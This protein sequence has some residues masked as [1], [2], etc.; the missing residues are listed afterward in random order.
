MLLLSSMNL[1]C[2]CWAKSWARATGKLIGGGSGLWSGT[3]LAS[4]S[5]HGL[6]DELHDHIPQLAGQGKGRIPGPV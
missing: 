4:G 2:C 6:A 3:G 1:G 5:I